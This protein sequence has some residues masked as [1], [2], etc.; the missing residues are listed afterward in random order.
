MKQQTESS[1]VP[2]HELSYIT[3]MAD[4]ATT[5]AQHPQVELPEDTVGI[6]IT[7]LGITDIHQSDS[8]IA[9]ADEQPVELVK[10][11]VG[12]KMEADQAEAEAQDVG[13]GRRSATAGASHNQKR[14]HGEVFV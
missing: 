5:I 12:T 9:D 13:Q 3:L 14:L 8:A 2:N 4:H 7:S 6:A 10:V 1:Q 11:E